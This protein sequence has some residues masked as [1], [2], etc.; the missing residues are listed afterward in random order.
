LKT[1]VFVCDTHF[2]LQNTTHPP[3]RNAKRMPIDVEQ[4]ITNALMKHGAMDEASASGILK[5]LETTR[6]YQCETWS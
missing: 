5:K 2:F 6:R 3:P 1:D 4:A